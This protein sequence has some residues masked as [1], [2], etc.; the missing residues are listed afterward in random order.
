MDIVIYK[1]W[2][3]G[4]EMCHFLN[5]LDD[6]FLLE[7]L[8]GTVTEVKWKLREKKMKHRKGD[9]ESDIH[10]QKAVGAESWFRA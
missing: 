5:C 8:G 3:S 4:S 10:T 7:S 6:I 2:I 1:L 9:E